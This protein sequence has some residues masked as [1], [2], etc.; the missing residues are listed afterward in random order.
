MG[1]FGSLSS[2]SSLQDAQKKSATGLLLGNG[3]I[4]GLP[5]FGQYIQL[6]TQVS[7]HARALC[8]PLVYGVWT[9]KS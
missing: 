9:S 1:S 6:R 7:V 4:V 3:L 2:Y 5:Q 8:E